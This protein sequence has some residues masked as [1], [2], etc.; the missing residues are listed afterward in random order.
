MHTPTDLRL[1]PLRAACQRFVRLYD[2]AGTATFV[3]TACPGEADALLAQADELLGRTFRFQD[4]WDM[5]PCHT[6]YTLPAGEWLHSPNGDPEWIFM[7][8]RHDLMPKLWQAAQLTGEVKYLDALRG[9]LLDW[10][11]SNP[12]L[13]QGTD[14]TRTIDT[15][16]RC[17]NWCAM[18][19]P[20]LGQDTLSDEDALCLLDCMAR[21]YENMR[22]RYIDK[23][24]LSNWGVLQTTAICAGYAWFAP[25]L[26]DGGLEDWAW[27]TLEQELDLQILTDGAHWE[28]SAMYHVE[29]LNACV[30]LL[31]HLLYAEAAGQFLHD[32]ARCAIAQHHHWTN[33]EEAA[34]LPGQGFDRGQPGWLW[35]AVRVLSR[36]VLYTADPDCLQLPQCDSD[37]TD[38]RDVLARAAAMLEGG[39]IYRHA[40]GDTLDMDSTW[41]LGGLLREKFFTA[42]SCAPTHLNWDC[43]HAG[44][45][46]W[47]SDWSKD[48]DFTWLKN[49][50]LSSS[51]GHLDQTQLSL[52]HKGLPFLVDSGRYTYREDDPIRVLLKN[53][54]A[55]N[56]CVIDEQSGGRADGSWSYA[57]CGE[58]L[59]NWVC[60]DGPAS[61]AEMP[62]RGTLEDSTPYLI[63]RKVM[64]LAGGVWL[65]VQDVTCAGAHELKEYFHLDEAVR[66]EGGGCLWALHNGPAC[67]TLRSEKPLVIGQ[68][69]HSKRYN[70]KAEAPVL[71]KTTAMEGRSTTAVLLAAKGVAAA[72]A[73]VYQIGKQTPLPAEEVTAWDIELPDGTAWTLIL[74]HR[75]NY[76]GGKL[77]LCHGIPIYGKAVALRRDGARPCRYRLKT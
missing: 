24:D 51:H 44:N 48:A 12:I 66:P 71:I 61:Y 13:P 11:A 45:F 65:S 49:S 72:P 43:A 68:V 10:V 56:V 54:Q 38:V 32:E 42:V 74:F 22:A 4:R 27:R 2:P 41:L 53:P 17:M 67:L 23:Y 29:V 8:N 6:P 46:Y 30:R 35:G 18:L 14:A 50:T 64:A 7:L 60:H 21:Q 1:A 16:I 55:H 34:A 15:G 31:L 47:R 20:L 76:K 39:G 25:F 63:V 33:Q 58:V 37:T 52:Y 77:Y 9:Y 40:A 57:T 70:E 3:R 73:E 62:L 28:Q 36:H 5:E 59:K 75:E 19:L 26:P 69:I